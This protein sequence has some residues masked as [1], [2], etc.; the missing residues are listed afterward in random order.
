MTD[1]IKIFQHNICKSRIASLQLKDYCASNMI[2]IVLLKEPLIQQ[3]K[4]YAYEND[5]QIYKGDRAGAAIIILSEELRIIKLVQYTS[6][7]VVT[8]RVSK[9]DDTRAIT[10]VSAYFKYNMPTFCFV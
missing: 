7:Y 10:V 5:K 1:I 6:D 2:D 3:H 8:I 9:H 4:V